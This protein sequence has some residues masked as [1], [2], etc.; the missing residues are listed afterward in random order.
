MMLRKTLFILCIGFGQMALGADIYRP[1]SKEGELPLEIYVHNA[2]STWN[3]V[4][5]YYDLKEQKQLTKIIP[6]GQTQPLAWT[7]EIDAD[8]SFQA[9]SL[10]GLQGIYRTYKINFAIDPYKAV[11][12]KLR[13]ETTEQ[14]LMST[15]LILTLSPGWASWNIQLTPKYGILKQVDKFNK[16]F[17]IPESAQAASSSE[18]K[19]KDTPDKSIMLSRRELQERLAHEQKLLK[20]SDIIK[21]N[22]I[23]EILA[24]IHKTRT[25]IVAQYEIDK[26]LR[27]TKDGK[28]KVKAVLQQLQELFKTFIQLKKNSPMERSQAMTTLWEQG[29]AWSKLIGQTTT[30]N[31]I[32]EALKNLYT[33][34]KEEPAIEQ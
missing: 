17:G 30:K 10:L 27:L 4:L 6:A 28:N 7:N 1:I 5:Q 19:E 24:V 2:Q 11:I 29:T 32:Q 9:E 31:P 14:S 18:P 12:D 22:G 8:I 26:K 20:T 3:I 25:N 21:L 13:R 34:W 33:T 23:D 16:K 15:Q